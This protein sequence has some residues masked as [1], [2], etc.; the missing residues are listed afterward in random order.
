MR[1]ILDNYA[2]PDFVRKPL[3]NTPLMWYN[4]DVS[5]ILIVLWVTH[6]QYLTLLGHRR[7][8]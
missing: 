3:D 5:G 1:I 6:Q 7:N 8:K 2:P 4:I